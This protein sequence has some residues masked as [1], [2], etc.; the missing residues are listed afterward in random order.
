MAAVAF[1]KIPELAVTLTH[2]ALA[3]AAL[4]VAVV[5]PVAFQLLPLAAVAA[6][7]PPCTTR[8]GPVVLVAQ[9]VVFQLLLDVAAVLV[10]LDT[11]VG[12]EV[13]GVQVVVAQLG[14]VAVAAVQVCT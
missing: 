7:Q 13:T 5:Q 8:V 2:A 11:P 3:V 12:P 10:Q 6:V 14:A 1:V 9:V 4:T